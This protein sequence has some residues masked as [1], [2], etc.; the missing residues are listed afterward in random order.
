MKYLFE[1]TNATSQSI[2]NLNLLL[3]E[4]E[5]L[6]VKVQRWAQES[7]QNVKFSLKQKIGQIIVKIKSLFGI[8]TFGGGR[9]NVKIL[10]D[11]S[12][13]NKLARFI[14][15]TTTYK[16]ANF[17]PN[18][19][20]SYAGNINIVNTMIVNK[21]NR[22]AQKL[23]ALYQSMKG[24]MYSKEAKM[25]RH[26]ASNM[27]AINVNNEKTFRA[28]IVPFIRNML[29]ATK[30]L[31]TMVTKMY[32]SFSNLVSHMSTIQRKTKMKWSS[33]N[34][35]Y[36][37]SD[38]TGRCINYIA[39]ANKLLITTCENLINKINKILDYYYNAFGQEN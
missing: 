32:K 8:R 39:Y 4:E 37:K 33:N 35:R 23:Q 34:S 10:E 7:S 27:R 6:S 12:G 31:N 19:V 22:Q 2:N 15:G 25:A 24:E 3:E 26:A 11:I 9:G 16:V 29:I 1:D 28:Y 13:F 20:V 14:E 5:V 17:G 30:K 38:L 21:G 18:N 36:Q